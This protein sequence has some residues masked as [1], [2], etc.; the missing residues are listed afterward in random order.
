MLNLSAAIEI[1]S[2]VNAFRA[3]NQPEM[4]A[5][6][7]ANRTLAVACPWRMIT[8]IFGGSGSVATK[9]YVREFRAS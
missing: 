7:D 8:A 4:W 5:A 3:S 6:R 9:A 2:A 1:A